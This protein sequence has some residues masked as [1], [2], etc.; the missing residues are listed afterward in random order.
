MCRLHSVS[1]RRFRLHPFLIIN[2][3]GAVH[4]GAAHGTHPVHWGAT[5]VTH[6]VNHMVG[7]GAAEF[8]REGP[9]WVRPWKWVLV[10]G[11]CPIAS[12]WKVP[13]GMQK[14][15]SQPIHSYFGDPHGEEPQMCLVDLTDLINLGLS[16]VQ[17]S[18]LSKN[19]YQAA[20]QRSSKSGDAL[21]IQSNM[22]SELQTVR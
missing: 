12:L 5:H 19:M 20:A 22:A 3:G 9:R 10:L 7:T 1:G 13:E 17:I 14:T 6:P 21:H 4:W 11:R 2:P 8:G 18:L 15:Q 16:A